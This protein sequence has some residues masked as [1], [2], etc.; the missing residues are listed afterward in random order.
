MKKVTLSIPTELAERL[1]A[2]CKALKMKPA[3]RILQALERNVAPAK[4]F[5]KGWLPSQ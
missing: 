5:K 2:E 3:A 4:N 1:D